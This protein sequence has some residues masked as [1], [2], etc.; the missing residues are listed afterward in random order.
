MNPPIK[1]DEIIKGLRKLKFDK[2]SG[3]DH[4]VGERLRY[5]EYILVPHLN[6]LFNS[7]FN[8]GFL[9]FFWTKSI[10]VPVCK[11]GNAN[12]PDDYRGISSISVFCKIFTCN[13]NERLQN[14]E[15]DH[16]L[17]C[18]EQAGFRKGYSTTDDISILHNV[19]EPY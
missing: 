9:P 7:M 8:K 1:D 11:K 16:E 5:T 10:I 15:N 2:A 17:I 12:N 6:K 13:I 4:V 19:I 14:W 3:P 18:E